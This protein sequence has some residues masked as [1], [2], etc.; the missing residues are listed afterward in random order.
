VLWAALVA[1]LVIGLAAGAAR[2]VRRTR[3]LGLAEPPGIDPAEVAE[4]DARFAAVDAEQAQHRD[5]RLALQL[6]PLVERRV[7][8]RGVEAGPGR[9]AARIRFADG[10]TVLVRGADPGDVG[11]LAS[12]VRGRSVLP[13]SCSTDVDG[14]RLVFGSPRGRRTL[15]VLVTGFDQPD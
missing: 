10:T 6:N 13:A 4:I 9:Q 12:W 7:P 1:G 2:R 14:T 11:V 3:K 8:A 5:R 15:S